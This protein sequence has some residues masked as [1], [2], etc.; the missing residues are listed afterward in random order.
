[1]SPKSPRRAWQSRVFLG[2]LFTAAV[3]LVFAN[4]RT[5]S[6]DA[7]L[8]QEIRDLEMQKKNL[9]QKQLESIELLEYVMNDQFVEDAARTELHMKKPDENVIV[10]RT[11]G[12]EIVSST[13]KM[14]PR[15][16]RTNPIQWWYYFV[17]RERAF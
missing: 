2:I 6:R 8:R 3:L 7:E 11:E 5:Y 16:R 10:V 15:Q 12:V 13:E 9:S 14:T 4:I 1:M 17:Y